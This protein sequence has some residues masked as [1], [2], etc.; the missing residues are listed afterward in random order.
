M[1]R[2][3]IRSFRDVRPPKRVQ[4][5]LISS[6]RILSCPEVDNTRQRHHRRLLHYRHVNSRDWG[7]RKTHKLGSPPDVIALEGNNTEF[8]REILC[9]L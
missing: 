1:N 2:A 7:Y 6:K 3:I 8:L 4:N 5:A 9:N